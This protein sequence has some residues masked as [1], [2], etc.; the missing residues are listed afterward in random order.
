MKSL[1]RLA[2]WVGIVLLFPVLYLY[3]VSGLVAPIWAVVVLVACWLVL[4]LCAVRWV[5]RRPLV[6]LALPFVGVVF[7]LAVV[8]LGE[9]LFG[10]TA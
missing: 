10:W 4:G 7:W 6:V 5:R 8:S 9:V 1:V 3:V 2:G